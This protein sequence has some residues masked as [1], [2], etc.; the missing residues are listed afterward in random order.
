MKSTLNENTNKVERKFP[1]L[2]ET[3][4]GNVVMY[5][6]R[7]RGIYVYL[8]RDKHWSYLGTTCDFSIDTCKP[9]SGPVTLEND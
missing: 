6:S 4:E 3:T 1:C 5:T 9:F 8:R 7:G 2:A